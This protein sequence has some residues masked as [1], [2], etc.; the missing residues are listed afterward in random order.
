MRMKSTD[1]AA[2]GVEM[3]NATDAL[4]FLSTH[5]IN[6]TK[7]INS[8]GNRFFRWDNSK[9]S[10]VIKCDLP[11]WASNWRTGDSDAIFLFLI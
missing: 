2:N 8:L 3:Y 1:S 7:S 11:E 6:K 9:N 5:L 4:L 10:A